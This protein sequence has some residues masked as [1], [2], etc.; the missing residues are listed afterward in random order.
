MGNFISKLYE[1]YQ[2]IEILN[3]SQLKGISLF[4]LKEYLANYKM[5]CES[6]SINFTEFEQIFGTF[7]NNEEFIIWDT[8]TNGLIDSFELFSGL[9]L[10]CDCST[11]EKV[12]CLFEL[13]DFN[14]IQS[15]AF[16][17]LCYMIESCIASCFKMHKVGTQIPTI[18]VEE[19]LSGYFFQAERSTLNNLIRFVST[20]KEVKTFFKLFKI[21]PILNKNKTK[22][23]YIEF[24]IQ[25]DLYNQF[26]S[27]YLIDNLNQFSENQ[28]Y[29]LNTL[30]TSKIINNPRFD[31]FKNIIK[32][33]SKRLVY[34]RSLEKPQIYN[35]STIDY[36]L[37]LKW[38]Y[39]IRIND[40]KKPCQY[41]NGGNFSFS[42][43]QFTNQ[44]EKDFSQNSIL[45]YSIGKIVV[46]LFVRYN[47]QKFYLAHQNEVIS[48][49][50]SPKKGEYVAS[51]ELA[52]RPSIHIWESS[53]RKTLQ[54]LSGYHLNGV[55]LLSF[56]YDEDFLLT[57]GKKESSPILIYNWRKNII[58]YSFSMGDIVQD[59]SMIYFDYNNENDVINNFVLC[60]TKEIQ[61]IQ[62][63]NANIN[64]YYI[65][66]PPSL[67]KK[68]MIS[69]F[70]IK[71]D[72]GYL[73]T[74]ESE[75]EKKENNENNDK[76]NNNENI[77]NNSNSNSRSRIELLM[78]S[79]TLKNT[80]FAIL[81]GYM[82]GEVNL[83]NVNSGF[84]RQIAKYKSA[85]VAINSHSIGIIIGTAING[86]HILNKDT[87][88][89][90]YELQ[91]NSLEL[92]LIGLTLY[93]ID[94]SLTKILLVT[95]EGDIVELLIK[96]VENIQN[97]RINSIIKI[98]GTIN[99]FSI[100]NE[101][102]NNLIIGGDNQIILL[103][104]LNS[105]EPSDY[106]K[107]GKTITSI[108]S[109]CMKESGFVTAIGCSTGEVFIRLNW[110]NEIEKYDIF[111]DK[112]ITE[113]KFGIDD[114]MLVVCTQDKDL[115]IC[116]LTAENNKYVKVKS[117]KT[118]DGYP[119]SVNFDGDYNKMII[120]TSNWKFT[121]V[122]LNKFMVS[123]LGDE[124]LNTSFWIN[125][126]GRYII[127]PKSMS[128]T[129]NT[130]LI[131]IKHNFIC[132]SDELDN[133]HFW[134]NPNELNKN[135]GMIFRV[136][137]SHIQTM[138]ITSDDEF[139]ISSGLNDQMIC[140]WKIENVINDRN[141]ITTFESDFGNKQIYNSESDFIEEINMND[142]NLISE[143]NYSFSNDSTTSSNRNK[144][145]NN[146]SVRGFMNAN[147]N[148]IFS[149]ALT[150]FEKDTLILPTP[151]CLLLEY[152]YGSHVCERRDSVRYL[153]IFEHS[154]DPFKDKNDSNTELIKAILNEH[155]EK[156]S[157][158]EII[159]QLN[160]SQVKSSLNPYENHKF[161]SK[162]IIYFL[163]RFV[164][165]YNPIKNVQ[166]VYQGHKEKI[167]CIA[168]NNKNTLVASGEVCN[169]PIILVW[170]IETLETIN[171]IQ[172]GHQQGILHLVFSYNDEYLISIGFGLIY[173]LQIFCIK[174]RTSPIFCN[175]GNYPIF[176]VKPFN[177]NENNFITLGYKKITIWNIKGNMLHKIKQIESDEVKNIDGKLSMKIF[178]CCDLLDYSLGN[179]VETDII[180]GSN[181]GDITGISCNKFILLKTNAH[182]GSINC[183]KTTTKLGIN[184]GNVQY[185]VITTGEDGLIKIWDQFYNNLRIIDIYSV[186]E[187]SFISSEENSNIIKGIQ[188]LDIYTCEKGTI[189]FLLGTRSGD[190]IEINISNPNDLINNN[191]YSGNNSSDIA[192]RNASLPELNVRYNHIYSYPYSFNLNLKYYRTR[193][194]IH[195]LLPI[196]V[197]IS[198]DQ[199]LRIYDFERK[200]NIS[201]KNLGSSATCISFSH[202]GKLIAIGTIY[203]K[204]M[205][206]NCEIVED[207]RDN[208]SYGYKLQTLEPIQF[209]QMA[210]SYYNNNS[211]VK[212]QGITPVLL[213]KF[214]THGDFLA[215]SYDNKRTKDGKPQGGNMISIYMLRLS[216]KLQI[217][218]RRTMS[219]DL[220]LKYIDIT[221]PDNQ[222]QLTNLNKMET[223]STH[224]DFSE[225]DLFI[226]ITHQQLSFTKE[227]NNNPNNFIF[228]VWDLA[229]NQITVNQEKLHTLNFP[230]FTTSSAIF[231]RNLNSLYT[232]RETD[233]SN[234]NENNNNER[235]KIILTSVWQSF[236][237]FTSIAGSK[238]GTLHLFRSSSLVF[239]SELLNNFII[240]K[241]S[242]DEMGP[243][244]S[245]AGHIGSISKIESTTD[246]KFIFT[247]SSIDQCV[248]EWFVMN[249]DSLWDL[250]FYPLNHLINDP[251]MDVL[252]IDLFNALK[253]STWKNR[254][255]LLDIYNGLFD[256]ETKISL[257]LVHIYG[258]R[259]NDKRNN[260]KYDN[261]NRLIYSISS[262]IVYLTISP[263]GEM[264]QE[265]FVPIENYHNEY[266]MEIS[267]FTLSY[268]KKEIAIAFNGL[269][270][271][272]SRWEIST[273]LSLAKITI[274]FCCVINIIKYSYNKKKMIGYG[275]HKN[276]YA[277]VFI[278]DVDSSTVIASSTLIQSLPIKIKDMDFV[279]ITSDEFYTVGIQH[280]ALWN[281]R[282]CYLE[283]RN[284]P[285]KILKS[286]GDEDNDNLNDD[287]KINELTE[288]NKYGC[289]LLVDEKSKIDQITKVI[290]K[291]NPDSYI[292]CSFLN[293]ATFK[294]FSIL[295][296]DDGNLYTLEK[297]DL[298]TKNK[299]HNSPIIA[300][301]K[302]EE[303]NFLVS[304][305]M[306]GRV[307][308]FKVDD[309]TQKLK[310]FKI[311]R[312]IDENIDIPLK[313]ILASP[314]NN[315]Q[316]IALGMN[317]IA[318]GTKSG[319]ILEFQITDDMQI[320]NPNT[321][322]TPI[323]NVNFQDHDPPISISLDNNSNF[324][325][326][327]TSKGLLSV[328]NI[329]TFTSIHTY[330]F[331][332]N[333][334]Y[335]YHFKYQKKLLIVFENFISVLDT[336]EEGKF[337][338][339]PIFDL[340]T[341]EI[342]DVKIS[343]NEK[344]IA[345][346]SLI[347]N[348]NPVLDVYDIVNG[349]IHKN[350]VQNLNT[351]I[352]FIDFSKESS[353]I[354]LEDYLEEVLVIDI[355]QKKVINNK[356][357]FDMEWM[358]N[359]LKYSSNLKN[360][361]H[362][363][364]DTIKECI[365]VRHPEK[366]IVAVGDTLGCI[367]LF[368]YP[369]NEDD[370]YFLCRTDHIGKISN[371]FFSFDNQYL[372]TSSELDKAAYMYKWT[373]LDD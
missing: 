331:K 289:Y 173:S 11:E 35:N 171:I 2:K 278:I 179:S 108:D 10:F 117:L 350:Q 60:S 225:D 229:K 266:Q 31:K 48:I 141:A 316:S 168:L 313:E 343:P 291:E 237:S 53:N 298:T 249:E 107:I 215:I 21:H 72:V 148:N 263:K 287:N 236:H 57:C 214:S 1:D 170:V 52:N 354:L 127:S 235:D 47:E 305:S 367:R 181:F 352:K 101:V 19:Y 136:H 147:L 203:G 279:G 346:A 184:N 174:Y 153:H 63:K 4:K 22:F 304:G 82:T 197:I 66:I 335:I 116:E 332:V 111:G 16:F 274:N 160:F 327:I 155:M 192:L 105:N 357:F 27:N 74:N 187:I 234:N 43:G 320:I 169:N 301:E 347:E 172:T 157:I 314:E 62:I 121:I 46:E 340:Q 292:K 76:E 94:V 75:N 240:E 125:F 113:V 115:F 251:F 372:I 319:D 328:W 81:V 119:M 334:K 110:E 317:K 256:E 368:K 18:K 252:N 25:K 185:Y 20:S 99:S 299:Y 109:V 98:E 273:Q 78:M 91:L 231:S 228:I 261:S 65:Q 137:S 44:F 257:D 67:T 324:F 283:Y 143:L 24:K 163:S 154:E 96:D 55:H 333:A 90:K 364:E 49:A 15:L 272:I 300:L 242:L 100:I 29:Y 329:K 239:D 114:K 73:K 325:F 177:S 166:K 293:I 161:C 238:E 341:G 285:L 262:Y 275:L 351:R 149:R 28:S 182:Q 359:G 156:K 303:M 223:A 80:N 260:I 17:D 247:S 123:G 216:K 233:L 175:L 40:I 296:G 358:G 86:L 336:S 294:S 79:N 288:E 200:E 138:K 268:D 37:K 26:K 363:Y 204:V 264:L 212:N 269:T 198:V 366:D 68:E 286:Y 280:L 330:D 38:V 34:H 205:I 369:A 7:P 284:I 250:D 88:Q 5:V 201:I 244:R 199:T 208:K 360:I 83:F 356:G 130:L 246:E 30:E 135:S 322:N 307:I 206:I 158:N 102:D 64:N 126:N 71:G 145:D 218:N 217:V 8:D 129:S 3:C 209:I 227:I 365:I 308:L 146:I 258:R 323:G 50:I 87:L 32:N 370:K 265:F 271:I 131:G 219:N 112:T 84:I 310:L 23:G 97:E 51:G 230:K 211:N 259:A 194:A 245:Y 56:A 134:K 92:K 349:F 54:I 277:F 165:N 207:I 318:V 196:I 195:P 297:V 290:Y 42:S 213:T 302:N 311:F 321:L 164:I 276:Y 124:D 69:I 337:K 39:G 106:I 118:Q 282:G 152:I 139:L 361:H 162:R 338:K 309:K 345:V 226:L 104:N 151:T 220:Y 362:I 193:F 61:V 9:I 36:N 58:V 189:Y 295:S 186:K 159:K 128:M 348:T 353:F 6:F 178:L 122:D 59:V 344:L 33:S 315:V 243:N 326:S 224:I 132:A 270:A 89:E 253:I 221:I 190:L 13:Y 306:D 371:I 150:N 103:I 133:I 248:I 183:I 142:V 254:V 255:S 144:Y 355:Q 373:N 180:I 93:H 202:D 188:S 120:L 85:V 70:A 167:G 41:I 12:K 241:I 339:L 140:K 232:D 342:N 281:L 14:L 95:Y 45:I 222:Y 210:T 312:T 176:Y 77:N 267:T 191:N